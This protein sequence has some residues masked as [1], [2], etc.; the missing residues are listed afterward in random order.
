MNARP[1][2]E[3]DELHSGYGRVEVL[4]GLS[5]HV[6]EGEV[7]A[8]LGP[9]GVG[10]TTMLST[11]AGLLPVRSG[12]I[13]LHG[14]RISGRI[15]YDIARA[16]VLLVPEGRGVFPGLT[17]AENLDVAARADRRATA[18]ERADRVDAVVERFPR[19]GERRDQLAGTLSGGEQQMLALSRAF[20]ARPR[21]LLLDEISMGLAP[22]LV[23]QLF[24]AVA[25]LRAAG[26]TI[27]LVEQY[28]TYALANADR[29]YVMHRGRV[30]A[31]GT[32]AAL[33][34]A[35]VFDDAYLGA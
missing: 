11:I 16:G 8:V 20:A 35:G 17:V 19:L 21:V 31:E 1:L 3:V 13:R 25:D 29:A 10:K 32:P 23:E 7:V 12:S 24:E 14:R 28:L 9:N 22:I 2:L 27:V 5:L 15:P 30:Q 6:A 26:Q 34:D 4:R 33:V 18:A